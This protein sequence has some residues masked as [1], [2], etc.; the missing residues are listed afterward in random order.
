[1]RGN[2]ALRHD[3]VL[4]ISIVHETEIRASEPRIFD[5]RIQ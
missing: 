1:M 5:K 2:R 3:L 4:R